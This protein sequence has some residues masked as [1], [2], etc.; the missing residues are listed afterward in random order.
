MQAL[1]GGAMLAV[2]GS[3]ERIREVLGPDQGTL[4]VA[5][6]NGP[7]ATVLSGETAAV[8]RAAAALTEARVASTP[9]P[10]S[11]AFHSRLMRPVVDEIARLAGRVSS[12]PLRIP[13]ASTVRGDLLAAG[14]VLDAGYWAEQVCGP[15]RFAEAA[16]HLRAVAPTHVVEVGPRP[17][18]LALLRDLAGPHTALACCPGADSTGTELAG[19]VAALHRDGFDPD[20]ARWF[21]PAHRVRRRLPGYV[22]DDSTRFWFT[23]EAADRGPVAGP[24]VRVEAAAPAPRASQAA[25]PGLADAVRAAIAAVSG[26]DAGVLVPS[27]RLADDLGFD[28]VMAMRLA[29][30]LEPHLGGPD[31][32]DLA[33]LLPHLTT[34]GQLTA[35]VEGAAAAPA[36]KGAL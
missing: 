8:A 36:R 34:V 9:L 35:H 6:L 5:A 22:F 21:E 19:V 31:R 11:H 12:Q 29:D 24:R 33:D 18:L 4:D 16:E 20:W 3:A 27:A 1:P 26:H 10:V 28:S 23:A 30:A 7:R 14:T 32:F 13:L 25:A 15:V 17:V 2:R